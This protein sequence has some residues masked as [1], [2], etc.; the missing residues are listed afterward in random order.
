MITK[1]EILNY[2]SHKRTILD[3]PTPGLT[4]FIG[5]SDRGKSGCFRAFNFARTNSPLGKNMFPLYWEGESTVKVFFDTGEVVTRSKSDSVNNYSYLIPGEEEKTVNAGT[6]VP[7]E[8][9]AIFNMDEVNYQSQIDR[10][11]LMFDTAGQRGRVL[12]KIVGLDSIDITL[13]AAKRDVNHLNQE[14]GNQ[15]NIMESL[16]AKIQKYDSLPELD[17]LLIQCEQL[18]RLERQNTSV[19]SNVLQIKNSL[20]KK[21]KDL[22]AYFPIADAQTTILGIK[23]S[24]VSLKNSQDEV[25][26]I[27]RLKSELISKKKKVKKLHLLQSAEW[28]L[29][30]VSE[31]EKELSV[32]STNNFTLSA[33]SNK[34]KLAKGRIELLEGWIEEEK[35]NIPKNCPTC[36]AEVKK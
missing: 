16:E 30:E 23:E 29:K 6:K 5:E 13:S 7:E 27:L 35:R 3:F 9:A 18:E 19:I 31:K 20:S 36:G 14:M 10:A 2:E 11:F 1:L 12:N 8:I 24:F 21:E 4:V 17:Q 15:K 34:I 25:E 28:L 32:L 33:I 26:K 22:E